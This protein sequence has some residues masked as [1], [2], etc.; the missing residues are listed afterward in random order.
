MACPH[1]SLINILMTCRDQQ[2]DEYVSKEFFQ[3]PVLR[4]ANNLEYTTEVATARFEHESMIRS[5][6]KI[7]R[8]H[9]PSA[10]EG[11]PSKFK[12]Q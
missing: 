8:I 3:G 1:L 2:S 10:L 5:R 11:S 12:P 6:H 9:I 4:Q 7:F